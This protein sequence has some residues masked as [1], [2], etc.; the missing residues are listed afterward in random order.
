MASETGNR[1]TVPAKY[2]TGAGS[3]RDFWISITVTVDNSSSPTKGSAT[4]KCIM[5]TSPSDYSPQ[6]TMTLSATGQTSVN[7]TYAEVDSGSTFL[8]K[9]F[10]WT[11]TTASASK[12]VKLVAYPT[13]AGTSYKSTASLSI[14]ISAKDHWTVS[15]NANGGSGAPSSQTKW[16][17][18]ALTLSST[19]PTRTNYVFKN[20]NTV[21]GGTGTAYSPGG[22]YTANSGAALYAQWYPPYTVAF[23]ANGGTG[24]PGNQ[25]KVYNTALTLSS[26]KPTR[27]DYEFIR[28]N[29]ASGGSGTNYNSG[30]TYTANANVTLYAQW[31][32]RY[33]PPTIRITDAARC[34]S[35]GALDDEGT[36]ALVTVAHTLYD[37]GSNAIQSASVTVNDVTQSTTYSTSGDDLSGTRTYLVAADM[38]DL[39]ASYPVTATLTDAGGAVSGIGYSTPTGTAIG[40]IPAAY[41]PIDILSGG[42]GIAFGM[43]CSDDGFHVGMNSIVEHGPTMNTVEIDTPS[44]LQIRDPANM[45]LSQDAALAASVY[46]DIAAVSD[47]SG[48]ERT[49][50]AHLR[51]VSLADGRQGVQVEAGRRMSDGLMVNNGLVLYVAADGTRTVYTHDAVPWM[52]MLRAGIRTTSTASDIVTAASGT[53]IIGAW[54]VR[55]GR[56]AQLQVNFTR[57]TDLSVVASGNIT[58]IVVATLNSGYRPYYSGCAAHSYGDNAGQVWYAIDTNGNIS[59]TACEGTGAARTIAKGTTFNVRAVYLLA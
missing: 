13:K 34:D 26:T 30:A 42:H 20:W 32:R 25:V 57:T 49:P 14:S 7:K 16:Y 4:V 27:T 55:W 18:T 39:T 12:T 48:D 53:T 58:D 24:A 43:P 35:A 29:T 11:K 54:C 56:V 5:H 8:T 22:S 9:T 40:A 6:T 23:N 19:K 47:M 50:R 17:G 31:T 46:G 3:S 45:P 1:V 51:F 10:T 33:S 15:Y 44:G 2:I 52:D 28:W 38:N 59:I 37:T 36:Y 41:Y 21:S